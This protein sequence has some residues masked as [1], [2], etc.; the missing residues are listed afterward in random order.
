MS[1]QSIFRLTEEEIRVLD[2]FQET[3]GLQYRVDGLRMILEL[4]SLVSNG[5]ARSS[6]CFTDGKKMTV[7]SAGALRAFQPE[8]QSLRSAHYQAHYVSQ[9]GRSD[10]VSSVEMLYRNTGNS[11]LYSGGEDE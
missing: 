10:V 6:A 5:G 3:M 11:H 7:L 9:P 4:F 8:D 1:R 2:E